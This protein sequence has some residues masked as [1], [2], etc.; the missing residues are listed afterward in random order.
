MLPYLNQNDSRSKLFSII[1]AL[2][3]L[4]FIAGN[5]IININI[6]ILVLIS[7]I[8]FG[9]EIFNVRIYF[10]DKLLISYFI[11][12]IFSGI[13]NDY[14]FYRNNHYW[15]ESY[16]YTTF[17]AVIF[18]KYLLLYFC[19]RY[20]LENKIISL[21]YFFISCT[22]ASVFVSVDLFYQSIFG[23]DMLGFEKPQDGRKLGGPFGD[24]LIAGGFIQ[25]FSIFSFFLLPLFYK[26]IS[27]KILKYI[28]PLL[29]ILFLLGIS[30]SGN[31][32]PLI[33]F[34][35]TVGLIVLFNKQ[36]RKY[37]LLFILIFII[38]FTVIINLNKTVKENVYSFKNQVINM[39]V[40]VSKNE[41]NK[42]NAPPYL[43][44]FSTFYDTWRLNKYFGGGVK[45]F[46]YYC[47]LR[48]NIEKNSKFICNMHPHNYHLEVLTEL[49]LV[50]FLIF[51]C[52][53][54]NILFITLF[55][56][57]F[58]SQSSLKNNNI[59]IPFIF[60]FITEIFP[61]KST[62]SFFTTG[63]TTYLFIIIGILV[64]LTRKENLFEKR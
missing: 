44:E 18:L 27:N 20:L 10:L 28:I 42:K 50:G 12:I 57:Y 37:F 23:T 64:A 45:N 48:P 60:L 30:L 6:I 2:F 62:G 22:F 3:P 19:L 16:F 47:H 26:E 11:L 59:I 4:S 40:A 8:L 13:L 38:F 25:R 9:K 46:R 14:H 33:L 51:S 56:K 63:N 7:I 55:K 29:F 58:S 15:R 61:I 35:F 39:Y 31:R 43:K 49:G 54:L 1:L 5:M 53:I 21:K 17:K 52:I 24:E 34:I 36:T 32:M 41:I